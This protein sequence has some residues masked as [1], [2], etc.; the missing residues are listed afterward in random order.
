MINELGWT[1][2][3]RLSKIVNVITESIRRN[4]IELTKLHINPYDEELY[5][6]ESILKFETLKVEINGTCANAKIFDAWM[7]QLA[8]RN[9]VDEVVSPQYGYDEYQGT[10]SFSLTL[11]LSI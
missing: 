1:R 11:K 6:K 4:E 5:R 10:G 3:E 9:W 7:N 2:Q 8:Q